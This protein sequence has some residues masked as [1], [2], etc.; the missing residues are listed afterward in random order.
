[1]RLFS[2]RSIV[3]GSLLLSGIYAQAADKL[4][5]V[6]VRDEHG[7]AISEAHIQVQGGPAESAQSGDD[8]CASVHA[9]P[10]SSVEVTKTGMARSVQ[11]VGEGGHVTVVMR[12][13]GS[14]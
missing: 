12:T 14:N 9:S 8:G 1:V 4:V 7:A 10:T 5:Q 2:L 13:A 6:C 3:L 11:Q